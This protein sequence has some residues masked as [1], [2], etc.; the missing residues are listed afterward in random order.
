MFLVSDEANQSGIFGG[1]EWSGDW[2][3]RF[4]REGQTALMRGG[5][6]GIDL[7]LREGEEIPFAPVL[8]GFYEGDRDQG[9]NA[10]RRC[11]LEHF[12]PRLGEERHLPPTYYNQFHYFTNLFDED[13]MR[14]QVDVAAE[15]GLEY[16]EI[17]AGWFVGIRDLDPS[18]PPGSPAEGGFSA[19]VGNWLEV[20]P[21]V[22]PSG[23]PAFRR[24]RAFQGD[25]LRSL[26]RAGA[27]VAHLDAGR[28]S[29]PSGC[30]RIEADRGQ[31][32]PEGDGHARTAGRPWPRMG[33]LTLETRK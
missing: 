24:L 27:S 16:F 28:A 3:V 11:L 10:L 29:I 33:W 5:S 20:D 25:A 6:W 13:I 8:L 32:T 21:A 22:F 15:L 19:G 1:L 31:S 18:L 2:Q 17:D 9:A 23:L 26:V 30:W 4:S 14:A 7:T 12:V